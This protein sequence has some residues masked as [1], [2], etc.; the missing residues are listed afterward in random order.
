MQIKN[1]L[2]DLDGTLINTNDLIFQS[3]RHTYNT[4]GLSVTD[5]DIYRYYGRPLGEPFSRF[6]PGREEELIDT[7]RQFNWEMHDELTLEFPGVKALLSE[8]V[9]RGYR[10]AIVTSKIRPVVLRGLRLFD[11]EQYFSTLVCAED[12]VEHKPHPAPVLKALELL[13]AESQE[14]AMIGDSPYDLLAGKAAGVTVVGVL[15]STFARQALEECRPD[16]LVAEPADL[17]QL[18]PPLDD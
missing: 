15:W 1:L 3:F 17:L 6:A 11:L 2:F 16:H 4:Y 5:E 7:Y 18:F 14:A 13:G 10:L 9:E 8:L 12:T